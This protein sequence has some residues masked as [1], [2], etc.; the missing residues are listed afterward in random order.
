M[1]GRTG[2]KKLG[3]GGGGGGGETILHRQT[4]HDLSKKLHLRHNNVVFMCI[5]Q[6]YI[7]CLCI[8]K[9]E[10]SI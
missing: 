9:S 7:S 10:L 2:E 5:F 3:G 1:H 4:L 8:T 6:G